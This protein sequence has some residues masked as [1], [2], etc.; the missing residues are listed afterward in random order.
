MNVLL[1][2]SKISECGVHQYGKRISNILKTENRFNFFYFEIDSD[3]EYRTV[4]STVNPDYI[5][6]NWHHSTM[7]WLSP[8]DTHQAS[9]KTK[10]LFIFHELN[11]PDMFYSDGYLMSDMSEDE[12]N[13]RFSILRPIFETNLEK[14]KNDIITIGSFGFGFHNKGFDKICKLVD[15][16]FDEAI[17][18]L[19][20]TNPFFGDYS[21]N[22]TNQIIDMCKSQIKN[23]KIKLEITTHFLDDVD[24]LNF[25]NTNDLNVFLYD[26]MYGRGLSSV[27]DY[28]VSVNTP[29]AV[30]NSYMFRHIVKETPNISISNNLTLKDILDLGTENVNFYKN[31]WNH[32]NFKNNIYKILCQI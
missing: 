13:K 14:N 16:S 7:P 15:E 26:D 31:K 11:L 29:I 6:Y 28:A 5:I 30:N 22:T 17:I 10:Q 2:N 1:I 12:N 27:I 4:I 19:H 23:K 18:R 9:K 21:G 8:H 3:E 25:L 24:I 32:T 20:I